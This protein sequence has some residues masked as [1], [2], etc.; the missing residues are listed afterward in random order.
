MTAYATLIRCAM[1]IVHHDCKPKRGRKAKPAVEFP[2][3]PIVSARKPRA[4]H[5]GEMRLGAPDEAQRTE[6]FRQL[7][8]GSDVIS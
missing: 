6:L 2:C 1:T 8:R 5:Y 7:P 3:G 4:R